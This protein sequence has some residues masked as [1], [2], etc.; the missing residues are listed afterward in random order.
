[1]TGENSPLTA[2][3]HEGLV[4]F[5]HVGQDFVPWC[6]CGWMG[7]PAKDRDSAAAEL[8]QHADEDSPP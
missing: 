2:S 8:L 1:M 6:L 7:S 4:G 3:E 5:E